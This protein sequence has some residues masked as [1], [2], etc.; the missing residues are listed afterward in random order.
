MLYRSRRRPRNLLGFLAPLLPLLGQPMTLEQSFEV[1]AWRFRV[2]V[3]EKELDHRPEGS[4]PAGSVQEDWTECPHPK[5][6]KIFSAEK[7]ILQKSFL[8]L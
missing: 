2:F 1:V 4:V 3:H 7:W 6:L 5:A 8:L